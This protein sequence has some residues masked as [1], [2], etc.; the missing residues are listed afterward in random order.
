MAHQLPNYLADY[1]ATTAAIREVKKIT[2][3]QRHSHMTNSTEA[4]EHVRKKNKLR[5]TN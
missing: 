5:G 4:I 2:T 1:L 3:P